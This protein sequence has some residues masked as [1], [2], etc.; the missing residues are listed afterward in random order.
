MEMG[1]EVGKGNHHRCGSVSTCK[2]IGLKFAEK[3]FIFSA[4]EPEARDCPKRGESDLQQG[5]PSQER[6]RET[7]L[8]NSKGKRF[9]LLLLRSLW[10]SEKER[11]EI[12]S[13]HFWA[14][15]R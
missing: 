6:S 5:G 8:G 3:S 15:K 13:L 12:N 9:T 10:A 11:K 2:S 1:A 14:C 7:G 4:E